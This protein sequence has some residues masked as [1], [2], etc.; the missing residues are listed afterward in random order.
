MTPALTSSTTP[1]C[2]KK[3]EESI[4]EFMVLAKA[5]LDS[6]EQ[7]RFSLTR[8]IYNVFVIIS[9][10]A[11]E[12]SCYKSECYYMK[13][14]FKATMQC[15]YEALKGSDALYSFVCTTVLGTLALIRE[16]GSVCHRQ[17]G[18]V[19]QTPRLF[20]L[21]KKLLQIDSAGRLK[22]YWSKVE[23]QAGE[24]KCTTDLLDAAYTFLTGGTGGTGAQ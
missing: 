20:L 15:L 10:S 19:I 18:T 23:E 2:V 22:E 6:A 13:D 8:M 4:D 9:T 21:T 7:Y 24:Y 17:K 1:S 14:T 3:L 12:N 11:P 16:D 5:A